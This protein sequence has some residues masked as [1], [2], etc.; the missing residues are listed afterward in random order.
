MLRDGR[1]DVSQTEEKPSAAFVDFAWHGA[2]I[3]AF[4]ASALGLQYLLSLLHYSSWLIKL[5]ITLLEVS[6]GISAL[7]HVLKAAT[8][9]LRGFKDFMRE[10]GWYSLVAAF[11][12]SDRRT[13]LRGIGL[14]ALLILT[15]VAGAMA[16]VLFGWFIGKQD[17][18][19]IGFLAVG[20]LAVLS[21]L[22]GD[23]L[24][25]IPRRWEYTAIILGAGGLSAG[26][27]LQQQDLNPIDV[28]LRTFGA[29]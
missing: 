16:A 24:K 17:V 7:G 2:A 23:V 29:A 3:L 12:R 1:Q 15:L 26:L 22:L 18:H 4:A 8:S 25:K 14:S 28:L 9:F 21:R 6:A 5:P 20:L 10:L 13:R 11:R 19:A 27:Y